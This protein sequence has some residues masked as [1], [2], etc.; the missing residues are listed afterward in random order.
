MKR[1]SFLHA[2]AVAAT[3]AGALTSIHAFAESTPTQGTLNSDAAVLKAVTVYAQ[4][5]GQ[6]LQNVPVAV[7]PVSG[8]ELNDQHLHDISQLALAVPSLQ[9]TT[10]NAFSLRGVG[11]QIFAS[12]VDSSVGVMVDGI[13]LG[14][15]LFMDNA[16]FMDVSQIEVLDGPQGILFGRN[17]SAGLIDIITKKPVLGETS[18]DISTEFDYRDT[19]PG[20]KTGGDAT[21]IFN[22]PTSSTSA[23]RINLL[24]SDQNPIS[25]AVVNTSPN[26]QGN[27]K[28]T[29]AKAKWLWEPTDDISAYI[30]ADYSRERG[31]GGIW[32]DTWRS[33]APNGLDSADAAKDGVTP[34]PHNLYRGVNGP[35][36]RSVDTGGL[37]FKLADKIS[38][39]LTLTNITGWQHYLL[40][41][42]LDVDFS[43]ASV[44][45]INHGDQNYNQYSE[46]LRLAFKSSRID[47]QTGLYTFYSKNHGDALF[48]G[49]GGS[50][51]QHLFYSTNAYYLTDRS[52]AA[53]G[54]VNFH[55]TN[56]LTLIGGARVTN[57][58]V[59]VNE[60]ADNFGCLSKPFGP[61]GPCFP[62]V[63]LLGPAQA[64]VASGSNTNVSY[65]I[66]PQYQLTPESM[67]Y[68]TWTTGY[69]GP[70]MNT[71]LSYIGQNPYLK[72]E[73][74]HDLEAGL[75]STLFSDRFRL[76][77][78]GYLE[79]FKNF[80]VQAFDQQAHS[81]LTNAEGVEAYGVEIY[82]AVKVTRHLTV[83]YNSTIGRA[84]F[85][86][87]TFDP[88]YVTQPT[89][90]CP[91]GTYFQGAGINTPTSARYSG[92]LDA[93]YEIPL[94]SGVL[95]FDGNWYHRSSINFSANGAPAQELRAIDVFG[96]N[97][98]YRMP[99]GL[100]V[101]VFC[102]NCTNDM[103]PDFIQIDPL[104]AN[105]N[106]ALSTFNRW[107]YNSVRTIGVAVDYEF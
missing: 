54:Q 66:G 46:E 72:P 35:D 12:N 3:V 8:R 16:A 68:L 60:T 11:S 106:H 37:S 15:P 99:N 98:S 100:R 32:D 13:S 69:K 48:D 101:T 44:L 6:N 78:D 39:N 79:K 41:Y 43:S 4:R 5:I 82:S 30:I 103:Y 74:V 91:N 59:T 52:L 94:G 105:I 107:G 21:L 14:V 85:T 42:N 33:V 77:V 7:T 62:L 56:S 97:A 76:N 61:N 22:I 29:E 92:T 64:V 88:C 47:W 18:G 87:F 34:G 84:Y 73:T 89:S 51:F 67:L 58:R 24:E 9:I 95:S 57:D 17:S 27:Q 80:Q 104:E 102:K 53:Y 26:Y 49:T 83:S 31:L 93:A 63:E 55:A 20:A 71:N 28:R 2:F 19:V 45:D 10:D 50:P 70:A 96:A 25:D 81:I 86:K 65:K 1:I 36:Y 75:K 23:L 38:P 40:H 90:S